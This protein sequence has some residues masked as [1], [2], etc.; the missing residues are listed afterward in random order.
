MKCIVPLA[1]G[2]LVHPQ[3]RFRPWF[4]VEGQP[5]L[6]LALG[7]RAWAAR[8]SSPDYIFVLRDVD[9]VD[10]LAGWLRDEWP[11]CTILR[12]S[13][14]SGG[15]MLTAL[16]GVAM[17]PD[18]DEAVVIDLADILFRTG[19]TD[20]ESMLTESVGAIIP[21]FI[22]SEP[23]YS[24]LRKEEGRVVEAAEKRVISECAS[25]GVYIFRDRN[26]YLSAAQYC[27]THAASMTVKGVHFICPMANGIIAA[28]LE[29]LAPMI[30]DLTPVSKMFHE[31]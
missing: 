20:P 7:Q 9:G 13:R 15:A 4:P 18:G 16:A 11:G 29:V 5:L 6:R 22:S 28:G 2:D 24:Y 25:A 31:A 10:L 19:P 21:C 30:D 14:M 23:C 8:L 1:G 12:L 26:S 3:Y 17:L 27:L